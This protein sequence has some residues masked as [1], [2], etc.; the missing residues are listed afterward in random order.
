MIRKRHLHAAVASCSLL[1]FTGAPGWLNASGDT[2]NAPSQAEIDEAARAR[3]AHRREEKEFRATRERVLAKRAADRRRRAAKVD[4][5][6]DSFWRKEQ[7]ARFGRQLILTI[8]L[9]RRVML[10][11]SRDPLQFHGRRAHM[12]RR[13]PRV[14]A[15]RPAPRDK[16][17]VT[18]LLN[19]RKGHFIFLSVPE[20]PGS[21]NL[22]GD[23]ELLSTV[24]NGETY[25]IVNI[26]SDGVDILLVEMEL[27]GRGGMA[28]RFFHWSVDRIYLER[29]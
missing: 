19:R 7:I 12:H 5:D 4:P 15:G 14:K 2:G 22:K 18:S 1:F 25:D 29:K 17:D 11:R 27:R 24:I 21:V 3:E 20:E 6:L 10:Y 28:G 23:V 9:G 16:V 26:Y 8:P 13:V